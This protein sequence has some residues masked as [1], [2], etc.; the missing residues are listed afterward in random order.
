[1]YVLGLIGLGENPGACIVRDGQLV[2]LGEEERFTRL[3]GSHG[4]FPSRAVAWCMQFA[5]C[6]LGDIDRIAFAWDAHEYPWTVGRHLARTFLAHRQRA[7]RAWRRE[8]GA[9]PYDVASELLLRWPVAVVRRGIGDGLRAAGLPRADEQLVGSWDAEARQ[10]RSALIVSRRCGRA[11]ARAV[12]Q[13]HA[14][15]VMAPFEFAG[16]PGRHDALVVLMGEHEQCVSL[17]PATWATR[18]WSHLGRSLPHAIARPAVEY[19]FD[20]SGFSWT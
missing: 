11:L 20:E 9:P 10:D 16:D 8:P 3:K 12:G 2:A 19:V 14:R 1:M 17:G 13:E 15:H 5:A 4:M 18:R 7:A 6:A